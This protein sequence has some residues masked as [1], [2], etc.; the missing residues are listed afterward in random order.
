[1]PMT[2]RHR[3]RFYAGAAWA[4]YR[5]SLRD[6]IEEVGGVFVPAA[7]W[8]P[9]AG[10]SDHLHLNAAGARTFSTRLGEWVR[11]RGSR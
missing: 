4:A 10:F 5:A 3:R 6:R 2:A 8:V 1:M 11:D 9:D 7:D